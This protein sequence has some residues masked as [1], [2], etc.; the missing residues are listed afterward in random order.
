MPELVLSKVA[1][2]RPFALPCLTLNLPSIEPAEEIP[3]KLFGTRLIVALLCLAAA[4]LNAQTSDREAQWR[5]DLQF[6]ADH[7]G[8]PGHSVDLK[9][10]I[11]TR[12]QKDFAKLYPPASFNATLASLRDDLP[13][14]SDDEI[15]LRL[16]RLV[17]SAN[18][19]H[20]TVSA[21]GE[22]FAARLPLGFT[23]YSDGLAVTSAA[24]EYANALGARVVKM[25]G[26]T[27]E[28]LLPQLAPYIA[29]ENEVRLRYTAA[30]FLR[31]KAVLQHF[32]LPGPDGRLALTLQKPGQE[33]FAI[34][35][36][37]AGP[38]T[39]QV[40][41]SEALHLPTPLFA[42]HPGA[43]YWYQ[44]LT[45]TQALYIQ[46]NRC[47]NDPRQPF[48]E[49]ARQALAEADAHPIKRVVID[50][51]WNGGGNSRIVGPLKSGLAQRAKSV[52]R[53]YVLIGPRTFSSA[54]DNALELHKD[55]HATLVGEATGGSPSGYGEAMQFVLPNSQLT[56][57]YTTKFFG[58][59]DAAPSSLQPQIPAPRTLADVLTGRDPALEAALGAQD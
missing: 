51:R 59:K 33:P 24:P 50:L 45:D 13:R 17:A 37:F 15:T 31:I 56:V 7:M 12:G 4:S 44:Y 42:S 23:W 29:H 47:E 46:Y 36:A 25:G 6:F 30:S 5:Q 28:Q 35:V 54:L 53:V 34:T 49:F 58:Q 8:A 43:S 18:V 38:Q 14:L 26:E 39:K 41:V 27:P 20:N 19:A 22:G 16:M 48:A 21:P 9:Y 11:I 57:Q 3:V 32:E 2:K 52:G 10:G 40:G 55:L 1:R